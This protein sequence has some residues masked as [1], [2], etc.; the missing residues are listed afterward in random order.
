MNANAN[1]NCECKEL[2]DKGVCDKGFI[3]NPSNWN[4]I[5]HVM[6]LIIQTTKTVSAETNQLIN[7]LKNV[8]E[9]LKKLLERLCL[10]ME[11]SVYVPAQ[12]VLSLL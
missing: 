8:M 2:I 10:S 3:W 9:M 12:F 11:M 4:V 5:N 1:V 6:L 7:W